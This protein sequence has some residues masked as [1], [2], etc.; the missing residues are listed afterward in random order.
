MTD[1]ILINREQALARERELEAKAKQWEAMYWARNDEFYKLDVRTSE[2]LRSLREQNAMWKQYYDEGTG[3]HNQHVCR[4]EQ[5]IS[6]MRNSADCLNSE[7]A[8]LREQ[9]ATLRAEVE[10]LQRLP[11]C[12]QSGCQ[13]CAE[14]DAMTREGG[15][16]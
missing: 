14:I 15:A 8:S 3:K 11:S 2:E 10:R 6:M 9:N 12:G 7:I 1:D 16:E 5:E 4:L 13:R